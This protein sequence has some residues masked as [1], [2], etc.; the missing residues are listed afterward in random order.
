VLWSILNL[1]HAALIDWDEGIF[2]LHGQW[3]STAGSQGKPFNFQTPPLFQLMVALVFAVVHAQPFVLPLI[4]IVFSCLSI[5]LVFVFGTMLYSSR[6]GLH[7]GCL[8]LF[9][10]ITVRKHSFIPVLWA[11]HDSGVLH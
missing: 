10:R 5:A 6:S 2:A 9:Q 4:S 1:Q 3:I 11:V 8:F 7:C